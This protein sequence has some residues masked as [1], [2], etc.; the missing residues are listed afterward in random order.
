MVVATIKSVSSQFKSKLDQ[1]AFPT[2]VLIGPNRLG[3]PVPPLKKC[4]P[5]VPWE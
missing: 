3:D 5:V 4:V 1:K 2:I